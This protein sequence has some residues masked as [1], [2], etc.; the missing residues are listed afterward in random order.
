MNAAN[1]GSTPLHWAARHG[2]T[3][4]A[5][6]LKAAGA[7][8]NPADNIGFTPLDWAKRHGQTE[9]AQALKAAGAKSRRA[10]IIM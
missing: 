10:C 8:V 3:E 7:D 4:T 2:H 1:F 9:T 6:A 5:Q